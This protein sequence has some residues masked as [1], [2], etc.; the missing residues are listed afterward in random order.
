[1]TAVEGTDVDIPT[2]DGTADAYLT[3]PAD[4]APH[5]AV[6]L[7]MDGFGLRPSLRAMADRLAG[8]GYTV[9][10]PNVLYREGRAPVVELPE[11]IDQASRPR[12]FERLGPMMRALT[13]D[14]VE[15]D[16][17]AYLRWLA[18]RPEAAGGPVAVAGYCMGA[19]L[20]L[21]TA[22]AYPDRVAATAGFHGGNLAT[23]APDSP[24]LVA[25]R[26][27]GEVYFA[28]ADDD[29]GMPAEQQERLEAALTAAGVT[30]RCE[31]YLGAHHGYTQADTSAYD[32]KAAERHWDALLG[33]LKRT[34]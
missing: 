4:G 18:G 12:I 11:F 16:A 30:H 29:P 17:D 26:L 10:V 3:H 8:A 21:R 5:P 32:E 20:A 27:T 15:R 23:E 25:G 34:F 22:G 2:G 14:Q 19:A 31:V 24:H 6:L 28:H 9:A 13:P 1:M 33:L 7:Y